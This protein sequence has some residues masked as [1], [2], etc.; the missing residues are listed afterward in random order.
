MNIKMV[1]TDLDGTLA[2]SDSSV[3][4]IDIET[5]KRIG[6]SGLC[7]VIATG[8]NYF[9]AC[10]VLSEDFP[11]DYLVFSCGAGIMNWK[12]KEIIQAQHLSKEQVEKIA[13]VLLD[14]QVDFSIQDKIPDNHHF[15][16]SLRNKDNEDF[17]RR[18]DI[19]NGYTRLLNVSKLEEASQII[20]I[21]GKETDWFDELSR[22]LDG[23]KVIRATS[24]LDGK[25]LWMEILPPHVSKSYG[26]DYLCHLLK[27]GRNQT[28]AIGNDYNDMDLLT[29]C[30]HSFVVANAPEELKKKY[31]AVASNDENGF[32]HMVNKLLH[33]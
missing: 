10:K 14:H 22:K 1:V 16:Y 21:L 26:V 33:R 11:I 32:T 29:Y 20:A 6:N 15:S 12:T 5:L 24:P 4:P 19:Y 13:A 8:R 25:T 23:V 27:I 31:P 2:R 17:K 7:R 9:S 3:C 28:V 18:L 30:K